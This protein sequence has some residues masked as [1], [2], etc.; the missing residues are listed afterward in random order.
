ML[1]KVRTIPGVGLGVALVFFGCLS[2]PVQ[3]CAIFAL[4]DTNRTLFCNNED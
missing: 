1:A 3:A 2:V 4:T